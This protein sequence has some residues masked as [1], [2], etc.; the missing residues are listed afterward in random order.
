MYP[1]WA[2]KYTIILLAHQ[3][4]SCFKNDD[5]FPPNPVDQ[6]K[7]VMADWWLPT[8]EETLLDNSSRNARTL[9]HVPLSMYRRKKSAAN[10]IFCFRNP[11]RQSNQE[12]R[13][14]ACNKSSVF[15]LINFWRFSGI[16][17]HFTCNLLTF[18]LFWP[19]SVAYLFVPFDLDV[20]PCTGC[21]YS[22]VPHWDGPF[23]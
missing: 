1:I 17:W 14:S 22:L 19:Y 21:F 2:R 18:Y 7:W 16:C 8:N 23:S 3:T 15:R 12:H 4:Y 10:Q 9:F 5:C 13:Q 20:L 6:K 11:P